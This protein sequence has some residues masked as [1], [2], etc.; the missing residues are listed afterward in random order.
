M[1]KCCVLLFFVLSS[2]CG[3]TDEVLYFDQF[4][5]I[6]K[7]Y[8]ERIAADFLKPGAYV[9]FC[10]YKLY[11]DGKDNGK[12]EYID[13]GSGEKEYQILG[14]V[15]LS[16]KD[17]ME[18][19]KLLSSMLK[20]NASTVGMGAIATHVCRVHNKNGKVIFETPCSYTINSYVKYPVNG[21]TEYFF[22][23]KKVLEKA[24]S[25]LPLNRKSIEHL[26]HGPAGRVLKAQR[27][28]RTERLRIESAQRDR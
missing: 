23:P 1:M 5:D 9:S 11:D 12:K 22:F 15:N 6:N 13:L 3:Y 27:D 21:Y 25:L 18:T 19:L 8:R 14:K 2:L 17:S 7:R 26:M 10:Y 28:K 20:R 24:L 16:H 4:R